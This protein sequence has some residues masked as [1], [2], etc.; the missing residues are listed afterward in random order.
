MESIPNHLAIIL[1]G[2]RRFAKKNN[3][4]SLKGHDQGYTNIKNVLDW[5]KEVDIK[6]LT[7]YTF[8][9]ENF[10]RPKKEVNYLMKLFVKAFSEFKT[11]KRIKDIRINI[12]G[13]IHLFPQKLQK[14]MYDL[15]EM[16]KSHT[17]FILN[18]AM[19]YGGRSEIID[20]TKKIAQQIKENKLDIENIDEETFKK[21]LYLNS[22]PD[23]I[24]RTSESRLS[25]FLTFQSVYSEIIFLPN[26]L[27]P[28]FSKTDFLSC[29]QEFSR[30][31]RRF[32]A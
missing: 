27:W 10:N 25:G 14:I 17:K 1:D 26:K 31:K 8:S 7:L 18:F 28:E 24:I 12:I 23:L 22:E 29:L 9:T 21:N 30:R 32:G 20:A 6:E 15:M 4:D 13:R 3:L 5:C 2:N 16:T 11:D 19:G